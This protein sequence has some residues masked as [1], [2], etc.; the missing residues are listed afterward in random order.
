MRHPLVQ[1][2]LLSK[3]Q[4]DSHA[5]NISFYKIT[6][7]RFANFKFSIAPKHF[8][9]SSSTPH[10]WF[11]TKY[12]IPHA[13]QM[14]LSLLPRQNAYVSLLMTPGSIFMKSRLHLNPL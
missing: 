13:M 12:K 2:R 1:S 9:F 3:M 8:P 7:N 6:D 14:H 11:K 4:H 5:T 10:I